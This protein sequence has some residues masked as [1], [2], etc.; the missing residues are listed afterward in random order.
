MTVRLRPAG[1]NNNT[2][3][4][5]F[6]ASIRNE[7]RVHVNGTFMTVMIEYDDYLLRDYVVYS[8]ETRGVCYI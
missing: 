1:F 7:S 6:F 5:P 3:N 2:E 4:E 8:N